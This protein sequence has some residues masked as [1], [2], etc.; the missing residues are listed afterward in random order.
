MP[1][2]LPSPVFRW[3]VP[4]Q[5]GTG[6]VPAA[7]YKAKFY[8]AGTSTP[9][10]IYDTAG[11]IYPSP[12]NTAT[13]NSEGY[14]GIKLG[15]GNYKLVVTTAADAVVYT[16]DNIGGDNTFGTGFVATVM[17]SEDSGGLAAADTSANQFVW[18]A[19]Y[20]QIGDGGHG[21]FWNETSIAADDGGYIIAS[22]FDSNKRW[23]RVPDED[24]AVRAASFGYVGTIN[25]DFT[26]Q[27]LAACAY[28]SAFNK[29]LKIGP[30]DE[31]TITD[32]FSSLHLYA[33]EFVFEAGSM[34]TAVAP[35]T[36]VVLHGVMRGTPEQHFTDCQAQFS[37]PQDNDKP[38]WFGAV[39]GA[40]DNATAFTAWF[41]S[42]PNGGSF[43][44]P[45]GTWSWT[46]NTA[47]FPYPTLPFTLLGTID[48]SVG[49]D[50]PPGLYLPTASRIRVNQ[51]ALTGGATIT[52]SGANA[53]VVGDVAVTGTVSATGQVN[54]TGSMG[55]DSSVGAGYGVGGGALTARV[56]TGGYRAAAILRNHV[57]IGAAA[58]SGTGATDL[59][60]WN[61]TSNSLVTDGDSVIVGASGVTGGGSGNKTF[62]LV[63]A[64]NTLFSLLLSADALSWDLRAE[65]F[66]RGSAGYYV[67]GSFGWWNGT[68]TFGTLGFQSSDTTGT[69]WG[70]S[71]T[72]KMVGTAAVG[73][74]TQNTLSVDFAVNYQPI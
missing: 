36:T 28:C 25:D 73:S 51:V 50:I 59:M 1:V 48:G 53:A 13:L 57:E 74:I 34:I 62:A 41:A 31:A 33:P 5:N 39:R 23:Y 8:A 27:L 10:A 18:C 29:T 71:N 44:L 19:G 21:F 38:E 16:Q 46:G 17:E 4:A 7:G 72:V 63:I 49:A 47:S 67:R 20:W 32:A 35:L 52:A 42:M 14:A 30:G 66:R 40:F 6:L 69:T 61:I 43:T 22:T 3:F 68:S 2:L 15:D 9:K 56:G 45:P 12:S 60:G 24:D 58:T 37:D 54:A 26:N 55:S 64:S 11:T 70:S 65:I